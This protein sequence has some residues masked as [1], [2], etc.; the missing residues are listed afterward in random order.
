MFELDK[1]FESFSLPVR[2]MLQGLGKCTLCPRKCKVNRFSAETGYCQIGANPLLSSA[3]PHFG[4]ESVL[5]GP[6]GSGTIFLSGCNLS[7]I[8]CQ[9]YQI[10]QETNGREVTI[11]QLAETML[12]LEEKGCCNVNFV[13]PTHVAASVAAAIELARQQGLKVPTVYNSGGYDSVSTI[14]KLA[15]LI[16]IGLTLTSPR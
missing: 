2:Q 12:T 7:C 5:V 3:G 15:G 4:E 8:F 14:R 11:E 13:S 16:V 10:S 6:G 1:D 9:N